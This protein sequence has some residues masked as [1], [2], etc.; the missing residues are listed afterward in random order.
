MTIAMLTRT[1]V[2]SVLV[3][4]ETVVPSRPMTTIR[5]AGA[6]S[7]RPLSRARLT[8]PPFRAQI[9]T[10][11]NNRKSPSRFA[12][13]QSLRGA[14]AARGEDPHRPH[15]QDDDDDEEDRRGQVDPQVVR[16]DVAE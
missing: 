10:D 3:L 8:E 12:R 16:Q 2:N 6:S 13:S 15:E 11:S 9:A 4:S 5:S 7:C 1:P 14:R